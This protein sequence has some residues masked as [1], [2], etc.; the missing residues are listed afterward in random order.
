MI[1]F[2]YVM[3]NFH[4]DL[5]S[6]FPKLT[7]FTIALGSDKLSLSVNINLETRVKF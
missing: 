1:E 6:F 3:I 2:S 4:I 7:K 5:R